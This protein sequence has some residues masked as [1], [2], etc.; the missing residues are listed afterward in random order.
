M[1][2]TKCKRDLP[3]SCFFPDRIHGGYYHTCKECRKQYVQRYS[4]PKY[5]YYE[6]CRIPVIKELVKK[7]CW[8]FKINVKDFYSD[9]RLKEFALARKWVCQQLKDTTDLSYVQIGLAIHYDH[10][11]VMYSCRQESRLA[12]AEYLQGGSPLIPIKRMNY[13]TGEI[14]VD[15][16]PEKKQK[17]IKIN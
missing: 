1:I 2:C 12:V 11:T 15:Y 5:T 10:T 6:P 14:T 16:I 7:A 4:K 17:W 8:I 13:Q 9:C 3:E